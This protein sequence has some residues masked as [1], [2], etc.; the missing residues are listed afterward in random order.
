MMNNL[1]M[2]I[3]QASGFTLIFPWSYKLKRVEARHG[4]KPPTK[5][6]LRAQDNKQDWE[7]HPSGCCFWGS[8]GWWAVKA[9]PSCC[10]NR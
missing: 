5:F 3:P 10:P 4:Y 6:L 1:C 8:P 2:C 7:W 9:V